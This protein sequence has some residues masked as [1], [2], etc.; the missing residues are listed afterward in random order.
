MIASRHSYIWKS[1]CHC[2]STETGADVGGIGAADRD[3]RSIGKR[4]RKPAFGTVDGGDEIVGDPVRAMHL[5]PGSRPRFIHGVGE[6]Q[7]DE[8]LAAAGSDERIVI[9][10]REM[11]QWPRF[12]GFRRRSSGGGSTGIASIAATAS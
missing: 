12:S 5:Q 7:Q 3:F 8:F 1:G 6:T 4:E 2:R 9:L 11:L 10:D